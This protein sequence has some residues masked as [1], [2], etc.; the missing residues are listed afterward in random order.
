MLTLS[1]NS[2]KNCKGINK[3]L[4]QPSLKAVLEV[5]PHNN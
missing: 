3:S 4:K 2:G 5:N 1:Q